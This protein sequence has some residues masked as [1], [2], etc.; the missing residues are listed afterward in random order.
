MSGYLLTII[1]TILLSAILTALTAE[2]KTASVIKSVTKM[3][4][5]LV[6]IMPILNFFQKGKLTFSGKENMSN[7]FSESVIQTE[8]AFIKYYSEMRIRQTEQALEKELNE[9][10]DVTAN[11]TLVWE[12][13]FSEVNKSYQTEQVRICQIQIHLQELQSEED[14]KAM[15]EY[16]TKNYCSEVLIE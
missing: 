10:F 13:L 11:V 15:W 9:K 14:K 6:I 8:Q 3:A 4:C 12:L 1:G 5:I 7:F 2:G 16:L